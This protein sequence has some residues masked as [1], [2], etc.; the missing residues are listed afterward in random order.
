M[1]FGVGRNSTGLLYKFILLLGVTTLAG[2]LIFASK[3][4]SIL[5]AKAGI[6]AISIAEKTRAVEGLLQQSELL[7]HEVNSRPDQGP[8]AHTNYENQKLLQELSTISTQ[9]KTQQNVLQLLTQ[10]KEA[11]QN[12]GHLIYGIAAAIVTVSLVLIVYGFLGWHYH[13]R[14]FKDRRATKRST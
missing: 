6:I 2:T 11:I 4:G 10:S 13:L 3:E 5:Q 14:I 8:N 7:D 12:E 1:N 9:I